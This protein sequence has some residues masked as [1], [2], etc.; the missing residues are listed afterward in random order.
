MKQMTKEIGK[1]FL[2]P[3][4]KFLDMLEDKEVTAMDKVLYK[5]EFLV[6]SRHSIIDRE[7]DLLSKEAQACCVSVDENKWDFDGVYCLVHDT[8]KDIELPIWWNETVELYEKLDLNDQYGT[9]LVAS[10]KFLDEYVTRLTKEIWKLA[11]TMTVDWKKLAELKKCV[12]VPVVAHI[13]TIVKDELGLDEVDEDVKKNALW[14][15]EDKSV[16]YPEFQT[17]SVKICLQDIVYHGCA[18]HEQVA[19]QEFTYIYKTREREIKCTVT[20]LD[21]TK[22]KLHFVTEKKE[23]PYFYLVWNGHMTEEMMECITMITDASEYRYSTE[24]EDD[25]TSGIYIREQEGDNI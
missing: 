16:I 11:L 12:P 24:Y 22:V 13:N 15:I 20:P 5:V 9:K 21:G 14:Y 19:Q 10:S 2:I 8:D 7:Y 6:M 18:I 4:N 17:D 3:R 23:D 1:P 25:K